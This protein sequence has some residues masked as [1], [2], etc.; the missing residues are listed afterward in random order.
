MG[1]VLGLPL[2]PLVVHAAVVLVPLGALGA[3]AILLSERLRDRYGWLVVAAVVA[4]AAAAL[5]SRLSGELF[6]QTSGAGGP[7]VDTHR[8]W[9][10]IA[11]FPAIALA[12][13]LP[14][15]LLVRERSPAGWWVAAVLSMLAAVVSLVLI[16]LTGH[17]GATAV[18]GSLAG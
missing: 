11:P 10:L 12:V 9:G 14:L 18:W 8:M 6:L 5:T 1:D 16:V 17:S 4:A 13:T 2:H 7:A 3:I 15:A